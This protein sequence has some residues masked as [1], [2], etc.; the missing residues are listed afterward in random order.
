MDFELRDGDG[1]GGGAHNEIK[2]VRRLFENNR[3]RLDVAP[4]AG[5]AEGAR[6]GK[7]KW[8]AKEF[9]TLRAESKTVANL[10]GQKVAYDLVTTRQGASSDFLPIGN[11]RNANMDFINYDY[12]VTH[13]PKGDYY[14]FHRVP[15]LAKK[16]QALAGQRTTVWH[17]VVALHVPRDEDFST[18]GDNWAGAALTSWVEFMLR[19]R[20]LFD[21]TPLYQR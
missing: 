15:E 18:S 10:R 7:A 4:F 13:S 9:T 6:E 12:F 14:P 2:L 5:D 19:P 21:S 1:N 11:A 3:F 8:V 16:G 20:N 17:S